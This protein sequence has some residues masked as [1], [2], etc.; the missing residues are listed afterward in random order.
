M[1]FNYFPTILSL[2]T[3]IAYYV[4]LVGLLVINMFNVLSMLITCVVYAFVCFAVM[5]NVQVGIARG[6][7]RMQVQRICVYFDR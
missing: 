5:T 3:R 7:K 2:T 4:K 1:H 6:K